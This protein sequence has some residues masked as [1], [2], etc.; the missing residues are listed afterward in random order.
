MGVASMNDR[1][2]IFLNS[3]FF[4]IGFVIV[5]SIV[6]LLLQLLVSGLAVMLRN[7]LMLIGGVI[8][9]IFGIILIVSGNRLVPFF[10]REYR[11]HFKGLGNSFLSS[12]VFGIAFAIGWTPCVGPI[13]G[14]IYT[15]A[16]TSPGISFL[17]LLAY[18]FGLG[19]PFL[20]AGA[21]ISRFSAFL[22][23]ASVFMKYFN[24]VSGI[25]LIAIGVLVVTGYI[26]LLSVFLVS[27]GNGY[28]Y[29]SLSGSLNFIIAILAGVLTFL[30]PCILPLVPAYISYMG[31]TA[32]SEVGK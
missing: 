1:E 11:L 2:R 19:I 8:I 18:S 13:L 31:G 14:S 4:V 23:R 9:I 17:L 3:I 7:S 29:L 32:V 24:L 15:L 22:K 20:V 5:F 21:F 28:G 25:F 30:S 10:S 6:G 27:S 16:A 26:G 12:L